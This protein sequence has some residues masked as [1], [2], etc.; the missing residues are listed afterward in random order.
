MT[1]I[2][3]FVDYLKNIT[4]IASWITKEFWKIRKEF[5]I[6]KNSDEIFVYFLIKFQYT[7]L[8]MA[9]KILKKSTNYRYLFDENAFRDYEPNE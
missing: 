2:K 8:K 4:S 6:S 7:I 3:K 1:D 9:L 5:A